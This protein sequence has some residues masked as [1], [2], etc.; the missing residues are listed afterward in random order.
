MRTH[1]AAFGEKNSWGDL[2]VSWCWQ[3]GRGGEHCELGSKSFKGMEMPTVTK[4]VVIA[5]L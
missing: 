5:E 1:S 4:T 3:M 2:T